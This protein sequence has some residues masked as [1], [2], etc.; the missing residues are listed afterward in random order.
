MDDSAKPDYRERYEGLLD[1]FGQLERAADN[2]DQMLRTVLGRVFFAID[3]A[4]P[5]LADD[6]HAVRNLLRQTGEQPLPLDQL[7]PMIEKLAERIRQIEATQITPDRQEQPLTGSPRTRERNESMREFLGLLLERIAFTQ[8][9]E[10]RRARL[11]STLENPGDQTLTSIL[12]DRAACLIN[13]MRR[14]IE[15]EKTDLTNFLKQ[16]TDALSDMDQRSQSDLDQI[17]AQRDAHAN[18][19]AEVEKHVGEVDQSMA[20]VTDVDQLKTVVRERL[21]RIRGQIHRFRDDEEQ[22]LQQ[23][24]AENRRMREKLARL[25]KQTGDL[26]EQLQ[27]SHNRLLRDTLTG[28]PNRLALDERLSLE[29]ARAKR[30]GTPLCLAIWDVDHFKRINDTYGHQ[31]G[32]KALHVVGKTLAQ[33]IRDV[34]MVARFGGEEFVMLL[35]STGAEKAMDVVERIRSRLA[36]T[37]FRFKAEPLQITLSCGLTQFQPGEPP[38]DALARADEALYQAKDEGRNRCVRI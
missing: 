2:Q 38:E 11:L 6:S 10:P 3:K 13:D 22:R 27:A 26:S 18:L 21:E 8:A 33:L 31:A 4:Y 16:V 19:N 36:G 17:Q 30:D 14:M 1:E 37:A 24:E 7:Q 12:V 25:E 32:D 34:D 29:T 15:H 28:L 9:M 35:P 23:S 20:S 5:E